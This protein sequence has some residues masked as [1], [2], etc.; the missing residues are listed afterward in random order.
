MVWL[1]F[2]MTFGAGA[3]L[4]LLGGGGSVLVVPALVY[5]FGRSPM[6]ATAYSLVTVGVVSLAGAYFHGRRRPIPVRPILAFG[7]ASLAASY[8]TRAVV[9]PRLPPVVT[10]AGMAIDLNHLFM[11][12][13]AA[14]AAAAG[15]AML[16]RGCCAS[17]PAVAPLWVPLAGAATGALTALLGAGGGFLVLPALVL[18]VG[19]RMEDAVGASLLIVGGQAMAGSLGV[20]STAASF[21]VTFA[22]ALAATMLLGVAGGVGLHRFVAPARLRR[23]FGALVL[24]VAAVMVVLESI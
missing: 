13:F 15:V 3:A 5:F 18:L 9:V 10:I 11:Y 22:L 4:G 1:G 12:A 23:G 6:E 19:L 8:L 20:L 14:F 17:G 24:A 21:D 16:R 7:V 2:M